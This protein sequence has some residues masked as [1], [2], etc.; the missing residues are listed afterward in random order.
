MP[1]DAIVF[2]HKQTKGIVNGQWG[3]R[4]KALS[5][6]NIKNNPLET[7]YV[8]DSWGA[9][10]GYSSFGDLINDLGKGSNKQINATITEDLEEW[11]NLLRKIAKLK[12]EISLIEA[13]RANMLSGHEILRNY[14]EQQALLHEQIAT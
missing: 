10:W 4:G 5:E 2:N 6:G 3:H 7:P 8:L 13:E 12:A 14:R 1:S 11:Y 9:L